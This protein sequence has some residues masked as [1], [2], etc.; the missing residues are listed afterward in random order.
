MK[1]LMTI[2][3]I[4]ILLA[5]SL[6]AASFIDK[7]YGQITGP[8]Y[9]NVGVSL[10]L[11]SLVAAEIGFSPVAVKTMIQINDKPVV[12]KAINVLN[13]DTGMFSI[14]ANDEFF[15]YWKVLGNPSNLPKVFIKV[16]G[17]L[18][19]TSVTNTVDWKASWADV[20]GAYNATNVVFSGGNPDDSRKQVFPDSTIETNSN[21][22]TSYCIS[23]KVKLETLE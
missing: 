22:L 14:D 3:L 15:M 2:L 18:R 11:S 5:A 1:K 10:S 8:Q 21:A 20:N 19:N 4:S 12:S 7:V 16:S 23:K 13:S 9:A 6:P 17:P